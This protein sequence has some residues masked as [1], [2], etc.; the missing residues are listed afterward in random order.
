MKWTAK[1][2]PSQEGKTI[3]VTGANSGLGFVTAKRL[4]EAGATVILACRNPE[5]GYK[6][7]SLLNADNPKGK[8]VFMSLDLADFDSIR[9]FASSFASAYPS[10]DILINN[11]GVMTPPLRKTKQ[12][13]E[14][15]YGTNYLGHFLLTNLLLPLLEKGSDPRIVFLS[16]IAHRIAKIDFDNLSAEKYYKKVRAYG[17]SKLMA[18]LFMDSLH[19]FLTEKGSPV[20]VYAAHPGW[21][22]TSLG[23]NMSGLFQR[24]FA[25]GQSVEKGVLPTLYAATSLEAVPGEYYGPRGLFELMGYPKKAKRSRYSRKQELVD[26]LWA[27][28][29]TETGVEFE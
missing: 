16:S 29:M 24:M 17:N 19:R 18:L 14:L 11:A 8:A 22:N 1:D 3:I 5:R 6:A 10:L 15:Q 13:H 25:L 7:E 28:S 26:R 12:G 20:H 9:D 21:T 4:V 27:L 2:I 23:Q